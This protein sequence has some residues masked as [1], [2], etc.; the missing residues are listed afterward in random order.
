LLLGLL[1]WRSRR[2]READVEV[3]HNQGSDVQLEVLPPPS[4]DPAWREGQHER[5]GTNGVMNALASRAQDQEQGPH[6]DGLLG[7]RTSAI[8]EDQRAREARWQ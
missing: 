8:L 1:I 5:G 4:Y 6:K 7:A 3:N 2:K